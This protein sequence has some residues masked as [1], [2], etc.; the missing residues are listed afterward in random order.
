MAQNRRFGQH[1]P[2]KRNTFDPNDSTNSIMASYMKRLQSVP[3]LQHNELVE[4]F[5]TYE[6]GGPT[7]IKVKKVL[8]ERNLPL[9]VSIVRQY[10]K[11]S[12][13]I[14]DL[15][16]EG[17]L[18]LIK[19]V[20]RFKYDRGFHFS[21]YASWWIKQAVQQCLSKSKRMVR[22]PAHAINVQRQLIK[23][24]EKLENEL[25]HKPS[26]QEILEACPASHVVAHATMHSCRGTISLQ[27]PLNKGVGCEETFEDR[28]VSDDDP[29]RNVSDKQALQLV[30][31][32]MKGLSAKEEAILRLRFGLTDDIDDNEFVACEEDFE[33]LRSES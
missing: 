20:E 2:S 26:Q 4:L 32:V 13:P 3:R 10:A 1:T 29:E 5:K 17:N 16:G 12:I 21:T 33:E 22:L 25:D 30:Q 15:V 23:T 31:D 27:Q 9:V 24:T 7:A 14:M 8:V 28:I 19:A 11:S 6:A 18:G